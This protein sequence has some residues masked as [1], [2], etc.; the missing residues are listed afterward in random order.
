MTPERPLVA[1]QTLGQYRILKLLGSGGMGQVY[2]A[3]DT[4]LDRSV[5]IKILAQSVSERPEFRARFRREAQALAK[6]NHPNICVIHDVGHQDGLDYIVMEHLEGETLA[7]RLEKGGIPPGDVIKFASEIADALDTV[8]RQGVIHRDLKPGNIMLTK[9]GTKLLDFGLANLVPNSN[10]ALSTMTEMDITAEGTIVGTLHYMA[11]EQVQGK[12]ADARSDIFSLGTILYELLTGQ[13]AFDGKNP[14]SVVAAILNREPDPF[15]KLNDP[16]SKALDYVIRKCIAK[17]PDDRF[18]S[19]HDL[20]LHLRWIAQEDGTSTSQP[21]RSARSFKAVLLVGTLAIIFATSLL[22][23]RRNAEPTEQAT[24][25]RFPMY[26]PLDRNF[27]SP[28]YVSPDGRLVAFVSLNENGDHLIWVRSLDSLEAKPLAGTEGTL[29]PFFWSPDSK[30]IG[31]FTST[32]LKKVTLPDGPAQ[33]LAEVRPFAS[34]ASGGGSWSHDGTILFVAGARGPLFRVSADGSGVPSAATALSEPQEEYA[35]VWPFFLP[36]GKHFLYEARTENFEKT[37]IYVGLLGST[38]RKRVLD[39]NALPAYAPPGY[40]LFTRGGKLLVQA[41]NAARLELSGDPMVVASSLKAM[42]AYSVSQNGILTLS[43]AQAPPKTQLIWFG[44]KGEQIRS[45]TSPDMFYDPVLSPSGREIA[46]ERV[47]GDKQ[48]IWLSDAERGGL[49][50]FTVEG[51]YDGT[52]VWSPD[53]K[54]IAFTTES[55][56]GSAGWAVR[57]KSTEGQGDAEDL[58]TL[59]RESYT[60]DWSPEGQ[61]IAYESLDVE[62]GWD[63]WVLPLGGDRK[64][65]A[66]L[67]TPAD[68]RE[69]QFSPDG[70]WI[71]YMSNLSGRY[72]VYV[73]RFPISGLPRLISSNGGAQ[74]R[75]SRNGRELYY[76]A[77]DQK[78]MAVPVKTSPEFE[79]GAPVALFQVR[80]HVSLDLDLSFRNLY[81]VSA[82]GQRFLINTLVERPPDPI[83][84]MLNWP[85]ALKQQ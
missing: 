44:R 23:I 67:K 63:C 66:V 75:W 64:P 77:S 74:P 73:Q 68:E 82:D 38:D 69:L 49:V 14:V 29:P 10:V 84:V 46:L 71:A 54:F 59:Q 53:G 6:V 50:R 5:A 78:L 24:L 85:A 15:E 35:H 25:M 76:L 72:E 52:P 30:Q 18:Q 27:L 42:G 1:G 83:T 55:P 61:F 21:M 65:Q 17:N 47:L 2:K 13:K 48:N 8:H 58:F 19:A 26:P 81:D 3:R 70:R 9:S 28:G 20:L 16:K 36:D 51:I 32:H 11:P 40:L 34:G 62:T 45:L 41:F 12:E 39:G 43:V 80:V 22:M 56:V 79:A 37:G 60:T 4:R 33:T 31:F 57:R 7:H